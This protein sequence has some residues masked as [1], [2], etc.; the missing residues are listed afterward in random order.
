LPRYLLIWM[1]FLAAAVAQKQDAHIN[2]TL[3]LAP[4]SARAR[5]LLKI[6]TDAVILAFLWILIYS[7]GLVTSITAHHRSTALQ[8]PMGLVYAALPV[9]AI[10]MSVY[11]FLQIADGVRRLKA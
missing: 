9:G 3:C 4:L 8:L 10:L 1:S 2:I 6:L 7:G 11:L 5:R